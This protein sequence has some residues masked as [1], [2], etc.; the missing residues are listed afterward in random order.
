[1]T[2]SFLLFKLASYFYPLFINTQKNEV[3]IIVSDYDIE[4]IVLDIYLHESKSAGVFVHSQRL[5]KEVLKFKQADLNDISSLY[6]KIERTIFEKTHIK[7]TSLRVHKKRFVD[8]INTHN[9]NLHR[10]DFSQALTSIINIVQ[11]AIDDNLLIIY[12]NPLVFKFI[13]QLFKILAINLSKITEEV[14][15]LIKRM[16]LALL[17]AE[18]DMSFLSH[19]YKKK[20]GAINVELLDISKE[21]NY[22]NSDELSKSFK[23]DT[24]AYLNLKSVVNFF[25]DIIEYEIPIGKKELKL[26]VQKLLYGIRSIELEWN[27]SPKPNIYNVFQRWL[28]RLIGFNLNLRKLSHWNIPEFFGNLIL[29]NIGLN[30]SIL[31]IL[32]DYDKSSNFHESIKYMIKLDLNNGEIYRV[33]SLNTHDIISEPLSDIESLRLKLMNEFFIQID[34]IIKIDKIILSELINTFLINF[35]DLTPLSLYKF[36][37]KFKECKYF[38][39]FPEFPAFVML[40]KKRFTSFLKD[41][42][43]VFID[44]HEF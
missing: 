37:R 34:L 16:D 17:F 21:V 2:D 20:D 23:Y 11:K 29:S 31:L 1:M 15:N 4:N 8:L 30:S 42:L 36:V 25:L 5:S 6:H 18:K 33:S 13:N 32:S 12:P 40:K 41:L 10:Y 14:A 24:I 27:I 43:S 35:K 19:I 22:I 9:L 28:L 39:V 3:D 44:R 26:I 38:D 7:I